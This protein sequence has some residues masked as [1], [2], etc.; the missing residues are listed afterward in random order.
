[1]FLWNLIAFLLFFASLYH[2]FRTHG[3]PLSTELGRATL[4]VTGLWFIG[5]LALWAI[6]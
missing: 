1:M 6:Q 4:S 5:S 3:R 2:I